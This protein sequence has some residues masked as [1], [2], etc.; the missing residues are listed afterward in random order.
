MGADNSGATFEIIDAE[1]FVRKVKISPSVV[2]AHAKALSTA[3]AK[4]P[5]NRVDVKTITIP[6]GTQSK[7]MDNIYLGMIAWLHNKWQSNKNINISGL[8]PRRCIIGFVTSSAFNASITENPFNFQHF[9]YSYLAVLLDSVLTP[10][11]PFVCDYDNHQFIR[12]YNSLFEGSNINHADVGNNIT[13]SG[14]PN[15]YALLAV[16]LTPDLSASGQHISLPKTGS[17]RI[18]VRFATPL[19]ASITAVIFSEFS[20]NIEIDKNRNVI[21]DYSS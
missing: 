6:V 3:T 12:A 5:I 10:T 1:L 14:Y 18:E 7:T 17:L 8:L 4:Y 11:K 20:G 19:T 13:R 2:M 21:T 15:G 9:S 16:D